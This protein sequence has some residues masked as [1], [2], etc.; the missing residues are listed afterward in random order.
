[1]LDQ[2]RFQGFYLNESKGFDSAMTL[3]KEEMRGRAPDELSP[4]GYAPPDEYLKS[5]DRLGTEYRELRDDMLDRAR[6][7]EKVEQDELVTLQRAEQL[8]ALASAP[9]PNVAQARLEDLKSGREAFN[10]SGGISGSRLIAKLAGLDES[11]G[12]RENFTVKVD[13]SG[14]RR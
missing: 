7:G 12:P 4:S 11:R 1:M 14:L 6:K 10:A 13:Y 5:V 3:A 9:G 8:Y 2:I